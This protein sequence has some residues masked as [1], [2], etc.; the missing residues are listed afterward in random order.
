MG[1]GVKGPADER[2]TADSMGRSVDR[3]ATDSFRSAARLA[4]TGAEPLSQNG[5]KIDLVRHSV[6]QA[7]T[8]ATKRLQAGAE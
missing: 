5:F 6:V 7:L 2:L 4:T 1:D 8:E 3:A